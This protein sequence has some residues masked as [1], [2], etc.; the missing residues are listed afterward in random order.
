M[1]LLRTS[2]PR[3][4]SPHV[5][6]LSMPIA[7]RGSVMDLHHDDVIAELAYMLADMCITSA[8]A[9]GL[10]TGAGYCVLPLCVTWSQCQLSTVRVS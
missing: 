1:T 8:C 9:L 3:N 10:E 5:H 6:H 7:Q 2:L 4:A